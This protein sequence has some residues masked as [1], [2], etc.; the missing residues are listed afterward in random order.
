L[1]V[2]SRARRFVTRLA[3]E[4]CLSYSIRIQKTSACQFFTLQGPGLRLTVIEGASP[5][6]DSG[7]RSLGSLLVSFN[8]FS[9]AYFIRSIFLADPMRNPRRS[10][11]DERRGVVRGR[12]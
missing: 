5:V 1:L 9:A 12:S 11:R 7:N 2:V 6:S 4:Y 8:R 10:L 3:D